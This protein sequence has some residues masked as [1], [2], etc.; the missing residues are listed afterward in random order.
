MLLPLLMAVLKYPNKATIEI[1]AKYGFSKIKRGHRKGVYIRPD[2]DDTDWEHVMHISADRLSISYIDQK[3]GKKRYCTGG[4][5][6]K[7]DNELVWLLDRL[8]MLPK[9]NVNGS[10][11]TVNVID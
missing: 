1:L 8:T 4:I 6:V 5:T 7:D 2:K 10:D 11:N 9:I 3:L